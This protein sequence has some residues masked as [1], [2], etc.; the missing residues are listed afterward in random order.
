[1]LENRS[2]NPVLETK[3]FTHNRLFAFS[4]LAALINYSATFSIIFLLSLYLQKVKGLSPRDAGSILVAQPIVMALFSPVTGRLS[5]KIQPRYLATAGMTMCTLGLAAFAFLSETTPIALIVILL[6]WVGTGFALFSS[7]NMNTIMSSVQKNQLGL[8]SGSASTMRVVGQI[9]SMTI[10]TL[11]FAVL[12]NK[13]AVETVANP[14]FLK[15]LKLGFITFATISL[16][17]IYFSF[18]RG[19]MTREHQIEK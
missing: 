12:F 6:F 11:F 7:P 4:N 2:E 8:A 17:G 1:M 19:K 5:D 16:A 13:Q 9:T 3:L 10:A 18:N 14:L 15:A